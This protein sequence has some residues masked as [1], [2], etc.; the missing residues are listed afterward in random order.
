MLIRPINRIRVVIAEK[1]TTNKW[2]ASTLNKDVTTISR[3]CSNEMQPSLSTLIKIA[4]ALDVDVKE[5]L[6]STKK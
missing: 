2:L 3:W 1:G 5:L 4:E 6:W